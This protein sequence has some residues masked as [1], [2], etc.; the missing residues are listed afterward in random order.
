VYPNP[1]ELIKIYDKTVPKVCALKA[2][3]LPTLNSLQPVLDILADMIAFDTSIPVG[4]SKTPSN[5]GSS[6][7]LD[8]D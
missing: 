8:M 5:A 1:D 4:G 3:L 6:G 7:I 2:T